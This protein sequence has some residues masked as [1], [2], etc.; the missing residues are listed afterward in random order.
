MHLLLITD[1][2]MS[3]YVYIM[4][5][6]LTDLCAIRQNVKLKNTFVD[7]AYNVLVVKKSCKNTKRIV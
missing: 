2:N 1:E 7:I 5:K 4:S 6:I 3:H